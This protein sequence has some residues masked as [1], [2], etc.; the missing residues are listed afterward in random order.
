MR[1]IESEREREGKRV[2]LS[3]HNAEVSSSI[4]AVLAALF[5][6]FD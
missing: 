3:S 6:Q 1:E 2:I 5:V 4:V